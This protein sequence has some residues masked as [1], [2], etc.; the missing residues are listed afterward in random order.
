MASFKLSTEELASLFEPDNIRH[1][2]SIE[3]LKNWGKIEG[4]ESLLHTNYRKGIYKDSKDHEARIKA[5]GDNQPIVKP[6]KTI[7]ELI[8]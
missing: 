1:G 2:D 3:A 6:P 5:Y 4:L 7:W 8:V